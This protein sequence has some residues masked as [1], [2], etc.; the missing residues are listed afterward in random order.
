MSGFEQDYIQVLDKAIPI[1]KQQEPQKGVNPEWIFAWWLKCKDIDM[2][3][4]PGI[5][6]TKEGT[7]EHPESEGR[8]AESH[9]GSSVRAASV[10]SL[11]KAGSGIACHTYKSGRCSIF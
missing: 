3:W 4:S 5:E 8:D 11:Q 10:H 7:E 2:T 1:L 6:S 9:S